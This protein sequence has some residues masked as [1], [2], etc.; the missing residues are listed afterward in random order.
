MSRVSFYT[1][2]YDRLEPY[3]GKLSRTVLRGGAGSNAS[4]LPDI[5]SEKDI[6]KLVNT[7][8]ANTKGDGE[9][10]GEDFWVKSERLFYCALIGYIHYEAPPEEQNFTTLLEFINAMEVRE[11]DEEYKNPVDRMFE[12]LEAEKPNHFAVRQYKKYS[13]AAGDI[14]SK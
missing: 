7:L 10:S 6:L 11:D 8:I 13:L 3:D 4:L 5:R 1:R 12:E 2:P 14:C 9:K